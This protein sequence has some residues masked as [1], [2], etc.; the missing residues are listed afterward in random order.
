MFI[1]GAGLLS[2]FDPVSFRVRNPA[3]MESLLRVK[4]LAGSHQSKGP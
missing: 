4:T 1:A 3:P 2:Q